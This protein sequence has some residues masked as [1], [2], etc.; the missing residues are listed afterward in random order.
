MGPAQLGDV[1]GLNDPLCPEKRPW[2]VNSQPSELP[3]C[4]SPAPRA[5]AQSKLCAELEEQESCLVPLP[6]H[7]S[8]SHSSEAE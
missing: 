4:P 1:K 6:C 2:E 8:P 7:A 5:A 3:L